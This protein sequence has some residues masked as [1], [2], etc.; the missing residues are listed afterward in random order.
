MIV[1][2]STSSNGYDDDDQDDNN[3]NNI[4]I[5]AMNRL[6]QSVFSSYNNSSNFD[7]VILS[8]VGAFSKIRRVFQL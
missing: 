2:I 4:I 1:Y 6:S 7:Q 3:N 5:I 8:L